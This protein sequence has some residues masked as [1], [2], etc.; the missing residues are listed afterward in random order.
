MRDFQKVLLDLKTI[1]A[2]HKPGENLSVPDSISTLEMDGGRKLAYVGAGLEHGENQPPVLLLHG[3]GGFFMDWPRIMASV[4]RQTRVYALDLPGWG[5]SDVNKS[6]RSLDD[7]VRVVEEF[8]KRQGLNRV[9]LCGIS[10]GAAVAWAAAAN[11]LSRLKRVILL[12][13]MPPHPLKFIHS[14][15]YKGVLLLSSFERTGLLGHRLLTKG[16]YKL[17]CRENLLNHRLLDSLYLDIA[18]M[19]VKQPKLAYMLRMHARGARDEN[20]NEWEHRLS[21]VRVPVSILQGLEDRIFSME[22]ASFV[23]RLIPT[24]ELIEVEQCGHAMVFDQH[25]KVSEL[26]IKLVQQPVAAASGLI[27]HK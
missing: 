18:Y 2:T 17:I 26:L 19:V 6:A 12:N 10:Y 3:F 8:M 15:L 16:Q 5:F 20:W 14:P 22:S 1:A 4:S 24:S 27:L 7:D 25:R 21:G 9:I 11:R 13:P 23:H